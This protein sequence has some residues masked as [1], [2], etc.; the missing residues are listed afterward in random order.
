MVEEGRTCVRSEGR[1]HLG[2]PNMK[3]WTEQGRVLGGSGGKL[4]WGQIVKNMRIKDF[5]EGGAWP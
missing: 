5:R 4:G 2:G 3:V 1:F